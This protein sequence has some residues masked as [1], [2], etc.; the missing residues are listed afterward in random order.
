MEISGL[1]LGSPRTKTHLDVAH[2][3][4]CKVYYKGEGGV[5]PQVHAVVVL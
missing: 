2:V 4:R 1:S 3:E 5:F